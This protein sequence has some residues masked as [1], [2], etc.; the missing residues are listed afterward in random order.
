MHSKTQIKVIKKS[1][2]KFYKT[3][4]ITKKSPKNNTTREISLTVSSWVNEFQLRSEVTKQSFDCL[5]A[6]K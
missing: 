1:N 6:Q 2:L 4:T 5:F 3:T